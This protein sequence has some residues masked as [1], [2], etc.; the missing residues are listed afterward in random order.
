M[1]EHQLATLGVLGCQIDCN[2][3]A[4]AHVSAHVFFTQTLVR[5]P[6]L[7]LVT[8]FCVILCLVMFTHVHMRTLPFTMIQEDML[9]NIC[10]YL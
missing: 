10:L 8:Y 6:V 2:C 9:N 4:C 7:C 3:S 1:F 5:T